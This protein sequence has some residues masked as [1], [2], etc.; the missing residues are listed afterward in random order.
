MKQN[1][2]ITGL[3]LLI[4][5]F[6]S[7]AKYTQSPA[8]NFDSTRFLSHTAIELVLNELPRYEIPQLSFIKTEST[9]QMSNIPTDQQLF[10]HTNFSFQNESVKLSL[11]Y[12]KQFVNHLHS[13]ITKTIY[14]NSSYL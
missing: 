6:V 13:R 12:K 2:K 8:S 9:D 3:I 1:Y 5:T 4:S 14:C 10:N 7:F 11:F